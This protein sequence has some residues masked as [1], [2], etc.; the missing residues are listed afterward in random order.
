[1]KNNGEMRAFI[2]H[3]ALDVIEISSNGALVIKK[4]VHLPSAGVIEIHINN[5]AINVN[6]EI[7]RTDKD[8][9]VLVFINEEQIN[10]LFVVLKH[11]RDE[12]KRKARKSS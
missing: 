9:M 6:Y 10:A 11:L 1:M 8:A 2:S 3:V 4:S 5:F 7:L 12:R